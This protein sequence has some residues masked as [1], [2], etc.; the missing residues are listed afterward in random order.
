MSVNQVIAESLN[1]WFI[2]SFLMS[3][4]TG[5]ADIRQRLLASCSH[6]EVNA[7]LAQLSWGAAFRVIRKWLWSSI[8]CTARTL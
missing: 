5:S 7:R 2:L 6:F 4:I 1:S 3:C 8:V